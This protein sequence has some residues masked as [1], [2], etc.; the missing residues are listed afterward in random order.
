MTNLIRTATLEEIKSFLISLGGGNQDD[1]M[2]K[3]GGFSGYFLIE[4]SEIEFFSLVFLQTAQVLAICPTG[5]D[6]TLRS[7]ADRALKIDAPFLYSNWDL[8]EVTRRT[9][10][11]LLAC[12]PIRPLVIRD[13]SPS[14]IN[15]GKYYLQDGCHSALG[16]AMSILSGNSTYSPAQAYCAT[17]NENP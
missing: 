10:E 5:S 11:R 7:V 17:D 6:R 15:Y 9:Q 16:Y 8:T 13:A 14:E 3:L 12:K 2:E 1:N 4:L